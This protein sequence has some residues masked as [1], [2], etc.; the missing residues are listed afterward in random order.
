MLTVSNV[1]GL[2]TLV[3]KIRYEICGAASDTTDAKTYSFTSVSIGTA[4]ADRLVVVSISAPGTEVATLASCTIAGSAATVVAEAESTGSSATSQHYICQR[5]VDTGTTATIAFTVTSSG[6]LRGAAIRVF[7][8]YGAKSTVFSTTTDIKST[9][10]N[11][12]ILSGT[13]NTVP[14]GF[15]IAGLTNADSA[16]PAAPLWAWTNATKQDDVRLETGRIYSNAYNNNLSSNSLIVTATYD[17]GESCDR[18]AF[19]VASWQPI[20]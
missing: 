16:D 1:S 18:A 5:V 19:A 8:L 6:N 2:G 12:G 14:G 4:A 15:V 3:P 11:D 13:V 7:A 10:D 9:N 20:F 17:P